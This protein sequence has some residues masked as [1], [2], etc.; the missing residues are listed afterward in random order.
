MPITTRPSACIEVWCDTPGCEPWDDGEV[1]GA[2][3]F[4]SVDEAFESMWLD[5]W[6]RL[7]GG[8]IQCPKCARRAD[9]AE[10]GHDW[11]TWSF[12][13]PVRGVPA[14]SPRLIRHCRHCLTDETSSD[15]W[16]CMHEL[17]GADGGPCP[18]C[19]IDM[20]Q[21]HGIDAPDRS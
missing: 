3:H 18:A 15:L 9:C 5:G 21:A 20:Y 16:A 4:T 19:G 12:V 7:P 14:I 8:T 11:T 1:C 6:R 17:H 10:H 2:I 13:G